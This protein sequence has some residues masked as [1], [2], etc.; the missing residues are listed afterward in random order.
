M[1]DFLSADIFLPLSTYRLKFL[2][3]DVYESINN[4]NSLYLDDLFVHKYIDY[5]LMNSHKLEQ[6]KLD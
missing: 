1:R 4:S 6:Q 3:I 2:T 5:Q